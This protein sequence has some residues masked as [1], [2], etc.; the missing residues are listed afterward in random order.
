MIIVGHQKGFRKVTNCQKFI[1]NVAD[2]LRS[3][4][5]SLYN[6]RKAQMRDL[7]EKKNVK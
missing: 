6:N 1:S 4:E 3:C 7:G 2:W 5:T